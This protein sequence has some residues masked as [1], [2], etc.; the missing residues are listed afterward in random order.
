VK[1]LRQAPVVVEI[2]VDGASVSVAVHAE[3]RESALGPFVNR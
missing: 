2:A 3:D 1:R